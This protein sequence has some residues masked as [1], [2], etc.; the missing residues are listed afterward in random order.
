[1]TVQTVEELAR[2]SREIAASTASIPLITQW[3]NVRIGEVAGTRRLRQYRR[4]RELILP[5][6][7]REG[8][9]TATRDSAII[10]GTGTTWDGTLEDGTYYLRVRSSW[11]RILDVDSATSLILESPFSENS[12]SDSSYRIVR[13]FHPLP[14]DTQ[15]MDN[16]VFV[17]T[18]LPLDHVSSDELDKNF[19][20]RWHATGG[21]P[22]YVAEVEPHFA[23]GARQ[24]EVYPYSNT[25]EIIAY[26]TW[27]KPPAL[28]WTQP[29]PNFVQPYALHEGL[30]VDLYRHNAAKAAQAGNIETAAYWRNESRAQATTW[31]RKKREALVQERGINDSQFMVRFLRQRYSH[32]FST[33]IRTAYEQ[34]W[35]AN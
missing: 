15:M 32:G 24:I 22:T 20:A 12:I 29:L 3:I 2:Y 9:V 14:D 11:Y 8:T 31:E 19:P 34:V 25:S 28:A 23:T 5:A 13:R 10:T 1:M 26:L 18:S 30:L 7:I 27:I 16:F 6:D 33:G 4:A 17:R 21:I 35:L